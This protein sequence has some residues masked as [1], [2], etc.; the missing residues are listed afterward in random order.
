VAREFDG[1]FTDAVAYYWAKRGVSSAAEVGAYSGRRSE[2][3]GGKQLDGFLGAISGVLIEA[4]VPS[5]W[6][7]WDTRSLTLVPGW[8]RATKSWDLLVVEPQARNR[9]AVLHGVIELKV[10]GGPSFGNNANNRAEEAIGNAVDLWHSF[11]EGGFLTASEPFVGYL[12]MVEDEPR[13]RSPVRVSEPYF[14][15]FPEF[16]GSCYIDR[17]AILCRRLVAERLYTAAVTITAAREDAREN[18]NYYEPDPEV[19]VDR[20][21]DALIRRVR[22]R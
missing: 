17:M 1:V 15:V 14:R 19:G 18:V 9:D 16:Q 22:P 5:E 12:I 10:L 7:A 21:F 4:G 8:F 3:V 11:R 20:F 13:S 2:V 6:I